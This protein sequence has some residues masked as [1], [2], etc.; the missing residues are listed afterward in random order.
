MPTSAKKA[1]FSLPA[2]LVA[3]LQQASKTEDR[4]QSVIVRRALEA[5]LTS[6]GQVS[7]ELAPE[8]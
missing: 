5:Y 4:S 1:T 3:R 7:S 2:A 6:N 8:A